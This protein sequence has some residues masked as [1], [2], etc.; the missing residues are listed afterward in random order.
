MK[1]LGIILMVFFVGCSFMYGQD[2]DY[3]AMI[4]GHTLYYGDFSEI[5]ALQNISAWLLERVVVAEGSGLRD[6][7]ECLETGTASPI[8]FALLIMNIAKV[9]FDI[10]LSL[11]FFSLEGDG[12]Y[13][14]V[15]LGEMVL[16]PLGLNL[17]YID[18]VILYVFSFNEV[19]GYSPKGVLNA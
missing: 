17:Y 6:P 18:A 4:S 15:L 8:E 13:V 7:A 1:F 12:P 2:E 10:E 9:Q 14:S 19:F 5:D 11:V 3:S 16:A